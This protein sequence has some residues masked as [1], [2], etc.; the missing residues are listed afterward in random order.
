MTETSN[1]RVIAQK[2][3]RKLVQSFGHRKA[4][5][6]SLS[7]E[8]GETIKTAVDTQNLHRGAF[9]LIARLDRMD[10]M[11]RNDFLRSLDLYRDYMETD[12]G[13][14]SAEPDMVDQAEA[15]AAGPTDD[16]KVETNVRTLRR[17]IKPLSKEVTG[18]PGAPEPAGEDAGAAAPSVTH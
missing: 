1:D 11:K 18:M 15:P 2:P 7:G 4:K 8:L 12:G 5:I 14:W 17:G 13:T 16:E 9:A 3:F 10:E 6:Q